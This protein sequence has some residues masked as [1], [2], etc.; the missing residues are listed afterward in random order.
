MLF[1]L[2]LWLKM[3]HVHVL[4]GCPLDSISKSVVFT[5]FIFVP[6]QRTNDRATAS[7]EQLSLIFCTVLLLQSFGLGGGW[8]G[9]GKAKDTQ[10]GCYCYQHEIKKKWDF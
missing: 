7:C 1:L 8:S 9:A 6:R 10:R 2:M 5:Y 4:L 3:L